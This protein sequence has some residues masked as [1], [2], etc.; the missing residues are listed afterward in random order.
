MT[1][2]PQAYKQEKFVSYSSESGRDSK[3]NIVLVDLLSESL[4]LDSLILIPHP[5]WN[6]DAVKHVALYNP[7]ENLY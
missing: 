5:S 4:I 6:C 2:I 3:I 1:K 7:G